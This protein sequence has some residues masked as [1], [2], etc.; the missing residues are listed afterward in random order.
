MVTGT[1]QLNGTDLE[2]RKML[3]KFIRIIFG[4]FAFVYL[5]LKLPVFGRRTSQDKIQQFNESANFIN[6]KFVNQERTTMDASLRT[7]LSIARDFIKPN[8]NRKPAAPLPVE[9]LAFSGEKQDTGTKVTWFGHSAFLIEIDGKRLLLDPMFGTAPSPF[10]A[11][12]GKRYSEKLPFE[13]EDLPFIDA[14]LFSH[15]HYDHL[16][17]GTI[18]KLRDKTGR[19]FVPLGV[20]SHLER[21]GVAPGNIEEHNWWDEMEFQGLSLACTP[22]RHFSGR[23]LTDRNAT[24]WCSWIITGQEEKIFFSG[25][26]GYGPH[27]KEIGEKYGPFDLALMECGQYDERWAALHMMPEETVQAHI[28]VKG[29]LMIPIHWGAFTLSVHDWTD[30]VERAQKAAKERGVLICTPKI[31]ETVHVSSEEYPT[32]PWWKA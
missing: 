25:D 8:P 18:K 17:Y 1:I 24:L 11:F 20:G 28:D 23:S 29:K 16:D 21:W 31:G 26:S 30:P 3:V 9:R 2:K 14:V 15:D 13:I 32:V 7:S 6:G 12:G 22:S 27:F 19:F 10:P 4:L 5:L